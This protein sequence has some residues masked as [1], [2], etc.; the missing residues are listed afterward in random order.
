MVCIRSTWCASP[1]QAESAQLHAGDTDA[2]KAAWQQL[3]EALTAEHAALWLDQGG[4]SHNH[5]LW[6]LLIDSM[7]ADR[8]DDHQHHTAGGG[9]PREVFV[10]T[11]SAVVNLQ[12]LLLGLCRKRPMLVKGPA[13]AWLLGWIVWLLGWAVGDTNTTVCWLFVYCT[14]IHHYATLQRTH[15]CTPVPCAGS[16][17]TVLIEEVAHRVGAPRLVRVHLDD[18]TDARSLLGAYVATHVAGEFVWQPGPL[19][20]VSH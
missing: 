13:G 8:R 5:S 3:Q 20:Q 16:G 19:A 1:R 11:P 14:T 12:R 18:Q 4:G 2:G 15:D 9:M 10:E 17:K 6:H 7:A